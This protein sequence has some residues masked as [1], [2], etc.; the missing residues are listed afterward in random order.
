LTTFRPSFSVSEDYTDNY[1]Q[2]E[3]SKDKEEDFSTK[4][5]LN[6]A[7]NSETRTSQIGVLY[8]PTYVDSHKHDDND[9]MEHLFNLDSVFNITKF[10][11]INF[12]NTFTSSKDRSLRTGKWEDHDTYSA[13]LGLNNRFAENSSRGVRASFSG[14][15][16]NTLNSDDHKTYNINT[17]ISYWFS[18]KYGYSAGLSAEKTTYETD[19]DKDTYSGNIKFSR[20]ITK[21]FDTYIAYK[22]SYSKEDNE[23]HKTYNPSA[24]FDWEISETSRAS[25]GVGVLFNKYSDQKDSNDLFIDADIYKLFDFSKRS[26]LSVYASSGYEETSEDAASLG[27]N[28]YYQGGYNYSYLLT[29]RLSFYV[30]GSYKT[31]DFKEEI[32][33]RKDN[34][35][36]LGTG[37]SWTIFKWMN[38]RIYYSYTKF[39]TDGKSRGDYEENKAGI[40]ISIYPSAVPRIDIENEGPGLT[41]QPYEK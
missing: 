26:S 37:L 8:S 5:R 16:Y 24:G 28:I 13:N 40:T 34:T 11:D 7:L 12:S 4:Y 33:D 23:T 35:L 2:V 31:Q 38:S 21:H 36:D 9:S 30:N 3:L 25:L 39:D 29:R 14:D 19:E 18:V 32:S 6:L 15:N 17:Y 22:Q 41:R 20:K 1:D 10:T 27:F